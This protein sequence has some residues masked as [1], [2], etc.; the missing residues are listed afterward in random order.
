MFSAAPPPSPLNA[1]PTTSPFSLKA[2]LQGGQGTDR[3][4]H[5]THPPELPWLMAASICGES[6]VGGKRLLQA[7]KLWQQE[8]DEEQEKNQTTK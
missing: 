3:D 8:D 6:D 7:S 5:R 1:T 4:K 2:G